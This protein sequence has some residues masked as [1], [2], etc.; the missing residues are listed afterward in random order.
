MTDYEGLAHWI[1][2]PED[3]Q[4]Y[5][6]LKLGN[7]GRR[8]VAAALRRAARVEA[9]AEHVV[10]WTFLDPYGLTDQA[11]GAIREGADG[12][13]LQAQIKALREAL[14]AS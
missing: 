11:A 1:G 3:Y 9:A 7:K 13:E 8:E 2:L 4:D 12:S 5:A 10:R 14:D 6:P